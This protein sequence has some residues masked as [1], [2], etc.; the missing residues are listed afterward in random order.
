MT[1]PTT[2]EQWAQ[3]DPANICFIIACTAFA[4]PIVPAVGLAYSGYSTR[5]SGLASFLPAVFSI[6]VVSIQWWA[7]GYTLAYSE[8]NGFFGD[9]TFAFHRGV[10]AD[11]VGAIPALLFSQFQLV[12]CATVCAISV[13]GFCER[14]RLLPIIPFILLWSTFVY[15]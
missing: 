4:W 1:S 6:A 11:P 9:L 3:Y 14:G 13:G 7:V 5:K 2:A 10:L 15:W 8:G 12:F